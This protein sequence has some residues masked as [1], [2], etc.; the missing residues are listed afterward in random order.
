MAGD[1]G[2]T[3]YSYLSCWDGLYSDKYYVNLF[4]AKQEGI[5]DIFIIVVTILLIGFLCYKGVPTPI[6]GVA[7]TLILLVYFGMNIYDGLLTTYM[8]GFVG[9]VQKWFLRSEERRVGKECL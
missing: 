9:F 1:V 8:G 2:V 3:M 7:C 5:M 4:N 6:G